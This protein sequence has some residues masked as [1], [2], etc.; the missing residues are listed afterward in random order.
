MRVIAK[1][2]FLLGKLSLM[3]KNDPCSGK[4]HI[5]VFKDP[6]PVNSVPTCSQAGVFGAVGMLGTIQAGGTIRYLTGVGDLLT[7]RILIFDALNMKFRTVNVNRR[8]WI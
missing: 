5:V 6:P 1:T 7:N 2:I 3:G 8:N 4:H